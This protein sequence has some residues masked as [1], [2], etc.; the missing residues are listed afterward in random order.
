MKIRKPKIA[1]VPFSYPDYPRN[2]VNT[3][4]DNSKKMLKEIGLDLIE[5]DPVITFRDVDAALSMLRKEEIDVIV[6]NLISW[7]EPPNLIAVLKDFKQK[8][9]I[10]WSHTMF[11]EAGELTTLGP[12]PAAG[13]IRETLEEMGFKFWFVWGMPEEEKLRTKISLY[14]CV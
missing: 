13:V 8:P 10:L 7:I 5:V 9:V 14:S 11:R 1:Y 6:A 4:V 2:I 12:L 3:L